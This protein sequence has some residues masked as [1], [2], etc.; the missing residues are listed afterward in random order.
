MP[1]YTETPLPGEAEKIETLKQIVLESQRK[2]YPQGTLARRFAHPKSHGL[3]HITFEV[4]PDLPDYL[5]QGL[6][7][8]PATYDGVI[9]FSLGAGGPNSYDVLPN[10]HGAAIKLFNVPGTKL[11]PGDEEST[12]HDFLLA[13]DDVFFFDK[14]E[15]MILFG[16]RDFGGLIRSQPQAPLRIIKALA[17]VLKSPLTTEYF[18]QVPY[19]FGDYAAKYSLIPAYALFG[20]RALGPVPAINP[21]DRDYLQHSLET[22]LQQDVGLEHFAFCVQLR[23]NGEKFDGGEPIEDPT[24]HWKGRRQLLA[25]VHCKPLNGRKLN[26][27]DGEALSFNPW[28]VLGKHQPLSWVGRARKIIYPADF[29][30]RTKQNQGA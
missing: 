27:S 15:Q 9:R 7:A 24:V 21:F 3:V 28:R 25:L 20:K 13:N 26:E 8:K 22:T 29:T 4:R 10:V 6:F 2:K 5:R 14:I 19:R 17:K 18:S 23:N 12:D 11:L 1:Y 30:W 16:K